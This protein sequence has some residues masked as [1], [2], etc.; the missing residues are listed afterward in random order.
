[1]QLKKALK[2]LESVDLAVVDVSQLTYLDSTI[3]GGLVGLR[4]AMALNGKAGLVHIIG[5]S[6]HIRRLFEVTG[7]ATIFDLDGNVP[8]ISFQSTDIFKGSRGP[9]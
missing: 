9:A 1:V 6:S 3:L 4:K 2:P 5:A 7:L 8:Q